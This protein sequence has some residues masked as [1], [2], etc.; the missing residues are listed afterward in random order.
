[1]IPAAAY[2]MVFL[3]SSVPIAVE[4]PQLFVRKFGFNA[5]QLDLQMLAI[6]IGSVLGE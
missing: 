5:Q 6:I 4:I 1:M 3:F 2:A